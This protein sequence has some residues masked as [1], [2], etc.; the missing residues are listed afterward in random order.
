MYLVLEFHVVISAHT[1]CVYLTMDISHV[2]NYHYVR[3]LQGI[4]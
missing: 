3:K 1:A 2:E 4:F